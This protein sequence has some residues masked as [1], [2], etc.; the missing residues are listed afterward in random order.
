[1]D[2]QIIAALIT[3]AFGLIT[4]IAVSKA[5]SIQ[6]DFWRKRRKLRQNWHGFTQRIA[7][8]NGVCQ[9]A[10]QHKCTMVIKQKWHKI[11][12]EMRTESENSQGQVRIYEY[13]IKQGVFE[14]DYLVLNLECKD[15]KMYRI[16]QH[17]FYVHTSGS[18][19]QGVFIGNR[20]SG[21]RVILGLC[22]MESN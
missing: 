6:F 18:L 12:G 15:E 3:G 4:G 9:L 13:S 7:V 5:E 14:G 8:E 21:E 16:R 20:A 10:G 17:L 11:S 2:S 1:M 19:L 22:N